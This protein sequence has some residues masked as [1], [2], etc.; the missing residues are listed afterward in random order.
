[1]TRR[2]LRPRKKTLNGGSN[3]YWGS[4]QEG[5]AR[6]YRLGIVASGDSDYGCLGV[7][8]YGLMGVY[9][10]DLTRESLWKDNLYRALLYL[11]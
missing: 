3:L 1:M 7:W 10:G 5:L 4:I 2:L 11:F 9:A 6:G 8:N